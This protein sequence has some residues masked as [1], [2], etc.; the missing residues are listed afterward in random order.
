MQMNTALDVREALPR[1]TVPTLV[2]HR[3][4]DPLVAVEHGRYLAERIPGAELVELPGADHWPWAG[5]ADTVLGEIEEFVTGAR[6]APEP[7]RALTTLLF[8]DIVGSTERA[9]E[10]GDRRWRELLEDHRDVVRRELERF[11]GREVQTTGDGF[12]VT[13]DGPTRAIR[14][15]AEVLRTVRELGLELR[16]GVHTGECEL[17]GGDL[18]GIAVHIAARVSAAAEAGEILVSGVVPDLVAG[19]PIRFIDRGTF[20][21]KGIDG[22]RR[23]YAAEVE[24]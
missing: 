9:R 1:I 20:S 5:D 18:G 7:E 19:S 14:C 11:G 13:F 17:V 21:L 2:L 24:R 22:E 3:T 8:T 23:L 12:L 15:A 6:G 10:L 4:G 16:A